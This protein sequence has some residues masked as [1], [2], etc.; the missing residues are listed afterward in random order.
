MVKNQKLMTVII[1][2]P[3]LSPWCLVEF[4]K[5]NKAC[6][7]LLDLQS[8]HCVNYEF[9]YETWGIEITPEEIGETYI[10]TAKV[11]KKA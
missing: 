3:F 9:L 7:Q 5:L 4:A 8:P 11:L 1:L 2:F 10:S 6:R